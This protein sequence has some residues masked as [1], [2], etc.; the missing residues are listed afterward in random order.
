MTKTWKIGLLLAAIP[1]LSWGMQSPHAVPIS[2]DATESESPFDGHYESTGADAGAKKAALDI[3]QVG[4]GVL[5]VKGSAGNAGAISGTLKPERLK[6]RF[7]NTAGCKL[8][9]LFHAE[10]LQAVANRRESLARRP[11]PRSTRHGGL[12]GALTCPPSLSS[13]THRAGRR[14]G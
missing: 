12:D 11:V 2:P 9:I 3:L 14:S 13:P 6:A 5:R 7:E 10:G 4:P 8:D 1:T